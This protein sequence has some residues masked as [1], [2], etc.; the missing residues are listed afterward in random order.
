MEYIT[1]AAVFNDWIVGWIIVMLKNNP[2]MYQR[3]EYILMSGVFILIVF[4]II[5][6]VMDI[7]SG[8]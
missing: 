8:R 6:A 7:K 3:L 4:W 5:R 2:L 1:G